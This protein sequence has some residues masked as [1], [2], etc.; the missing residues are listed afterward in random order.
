MRTQSLVIDGQAV[1]NALGK[2]AELKTFGAYN[3]NTFL[4]DKNW[5]AL[6]LHLIGSRNVPLP[7]KW[8]DFLALS[9][10]KRDLSTFLTD[11]LIAV[12]YPH[13]L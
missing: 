4:S 8:G 11:E 3:A 6:I 10:N 9:E 5:T 12:N 1:V 7:S 2:P 13:H